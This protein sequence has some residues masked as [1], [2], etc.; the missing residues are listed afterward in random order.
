MQVSLRVQASPSSQV[1]PSF[2]GGFEH[3]RVVDEH[4]PAT[5]HWSIGLQSASILQGQESPV[6]GAEQTPD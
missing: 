6:G 4:V 1:A 2:F 5:W 3:V